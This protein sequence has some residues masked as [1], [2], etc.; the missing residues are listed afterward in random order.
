MDEKSALSV[1][2]RQIV[3][4]GNYISSRYSEAQLISNLIAISSVC[5]CGVRAPGH[6]KS[7][8]GQFHD[9]EAGP[10]Q[11]PHPAWG[12]E[13]EQTETKVLYFLE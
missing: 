1:D 5:H 11:I 7:G 2:G 4:V 8:L 3:Q 13:S 9:G 12:R 10:R 6:S